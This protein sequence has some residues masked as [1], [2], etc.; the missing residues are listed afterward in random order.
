M[1]YC[2]CRAQKVEQ[3]LH[4]SL[5]TED[6]RVDILLL[7]LIIRNWLYQWRVLVIIS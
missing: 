5:N 7:P 6:A 2:I 4:L 3:E 1:Y